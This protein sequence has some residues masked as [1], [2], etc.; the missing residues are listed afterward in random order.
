LLRLPTGKDGDAA[1]AITL[2]L[3]FATPLPDPKEWCKP[4]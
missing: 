1:G 3:D 4:L 2:K